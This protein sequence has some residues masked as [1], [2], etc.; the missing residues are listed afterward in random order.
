MQPTV[1]PG[2]DVTIE[3]D[4]RRLRWPEEDEANSDCNLAMNR[5]YSDLRGLAWSDVAAA[6]AAERDYIWRLA[7]TGDPSREFV[8]IADERY[9]SDEYLH[10]LDLGVG[11]AVSALS[12]MGCVPASSCN[13]G[14]RRETIHAEDFPLVA[15]FA[16]PVSIPAIETAAR[17]AGAGLYNGD[18]GELVLYADTIGKLVAFAESALEAAQSAA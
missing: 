13:G 14:V 9:E 5:A 4:A 6:I 17:S 15:F 8:E 12:A 18:E 3:I 16:L 11:A 2:M 1:I 7:E 10:G